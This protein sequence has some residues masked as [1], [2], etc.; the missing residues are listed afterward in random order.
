MSENLGTIKILE[1]R[2]ITK[3]NDLTEI[4]STGGGD[5]FNYIVYNGITYR[6]LNGK[7]DKSLVTPKKKYEEIEEEIDNLD[8][9][10]DPFGE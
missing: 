9:L 5:P 10:D 1:G 6:L 2:I 7:E 8:D 3:K 4:W